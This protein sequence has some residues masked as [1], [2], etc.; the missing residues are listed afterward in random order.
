MKFAKLLFLFVT[1][2]FSVFSQ[3]KTATISGKVLD[4]NDR[5]LFKVSVSILG[6]EKGTTTN[7]SGGFSIKV[8]SDKPL[9]LIFSHT[10]YKTFQRNFNLLQGENENITVNLQPH[11]DVLQ[12]VTVKDNR[13]RTEAGRINIDPKKALLNPSP[14]GN[15]ESLIKIFTGS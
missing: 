12:E 10:G 13:P 14:L 1:I 15:I 4:E 7:D 6:K 8:T 3:K 5:P 9:A 11:T 2:C